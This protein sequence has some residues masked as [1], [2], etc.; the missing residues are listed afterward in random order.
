MTTILGVWRA[1]GAASDGPISNTTLLNTP[2]GV[3]SD[4]AGGYYFC[5]RSNAVVKR[6]FA[7]G[8]LVRVAGNTTARFLAQDGPATTIPLTGPTFL[9]LESSGGLWI[10]DQSKFVSRSCRSLLC[11]TLNPLLL[12]QHAVTPSTMSQRTGL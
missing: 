5:D 10:S 12:H 9:F 11:V 2:T 4:N 6:L 7:N 8:T 3:I 1:S